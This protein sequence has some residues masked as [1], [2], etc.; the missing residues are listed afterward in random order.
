MRASTVAAGEVALQNLWS[1]VH[2]DCSLARQWHFSN[3]AAHAQ[4]YL[5]DLQLLA[6]LA[7]VGALLD[8]GS[9]PCHMTALLQDSGYPVI[10]VDIAPQRVARL[11]DDLHLDVRQCDIERSPLPFPDEHF[12]GA[13]LC[14]TFEHLR[15]DPAFVLSEICRVLKHGGFLLLTTPNVYSLP[16]LARFVL[17]RSIAD[18]LTEFGKLRRL[19]HMGH[20]REYSCA[21]VRRFVMASGF[22]LESVGY[23]HD[24]RQ[25]CWRDRILRLAYRMAPRCFQRDIVIVARKRDRG[26]LLQPLP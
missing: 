10:G 19:G 17:G 7:P 11:I 6:A 4:R 25:R 12:S 1:A 14:D 3:L 8:V 23:R 21:E 2:R 15:I 16:S 18:P 22:S 20:V 13:L 9:A 5:A 24:D 26:P